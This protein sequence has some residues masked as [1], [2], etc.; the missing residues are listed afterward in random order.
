VCANQSVV[1]VYDENKTYSEYIY[2]KLVEIIQKM[3]MKAGGGAQ[4]HI[5]KDIVNNTKVILPDSDIIKKFN[6]I[7]KP[8]FDE[9]SILLFKNQN[10]SKTRDL[11]LPRLITGKVDVSELNIQVEVEA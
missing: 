2:L 4:Q 11:L 5:N 1:G 10:L 3:I 6:I 8:I 7:I 9:I